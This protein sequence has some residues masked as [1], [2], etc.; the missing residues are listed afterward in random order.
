MKDLIY[1][2]GKNGYYTYVSTYAAAQKQKATDPGFT[3]IAVAREIKNE[4]PALSPIR[5]KM[6]NQFGY[7]SPKFKNQVVIG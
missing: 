7:V 3:I 6:I 5:Q 4:V 2:V 1:K